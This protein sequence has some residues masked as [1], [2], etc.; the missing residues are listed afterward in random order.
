MKLKRKIFLLMVMTLSAWFTGCSTTMFAELG[1][2]FE[3]TEK[4]PKVYTLCHSEPMSLSY[5]RNLSHSLSYSTCFLP[6]D[7]EVKNLPDDFAVPLLYPKAEYNKYNSEQIDGTGVGIVSFCT[8]SK[9]EIQNAKCIFGKHSLLQSTTTVS[10]QTKLYSVIKQIAD[11]SHE[12]KK[13]KIFTIVVR[14]S[15]KEKNDFGAVRTNDKEHFPEGYKLPSVHAIQLEWNLEV[16][17]EYTTVQT[18]TGDDAVTTFENGKIEMITVKTPLG[19]FSVNKTE[20]PVIGLGKET[21]ERLYYTTKTIQENQ[22]AFEFTDSSSSDFNDLLLSLLS[23]KSPLNINKSYILVLKITKDC[24]DYF[25]T[26]TGWKIYPA[27]E[28]MKQYIRGYVG[29]TFWGNIENVCME[30]QVISTESG[31]EL[32]L[33]PQRYKTYY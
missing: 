22:F 25:L 30:V 15:W 11:N 33:Q 29:R 5:S 19:K 10:Y 8:D 26:E 23:S 14:D 31:Y 7:I 9:G 24:G 18:F 17:E 6:S 20:I 1:A 12:E 13:S 16:L 27:S 32:V 4:L 28:I 2:L 3:N 21:E